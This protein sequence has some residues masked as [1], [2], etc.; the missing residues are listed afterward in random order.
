MIRKSKHVSMVDMD[1]MRNVFGNNEIAISEYLEEFI[2]GTSTLLKNANHAIR[3][4][5]QIAAMDYF[6]QLKG[7]TGSIGFKKMYTLCKK[8]KKKS[9]NRIGVPLI[10]YVATWKKF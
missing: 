2:E 8:I 10:N 9:L 1:I 4:K 6:H 3:E 7:P 5:N